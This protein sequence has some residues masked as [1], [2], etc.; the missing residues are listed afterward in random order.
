MQ[1]QAINWQSVRADYNKHKNQWRM[2]YEA[3]STP[4]GDG[5]YKRHRKVVSIRLPILDQWNKT[6]DPKAKMEINLTK[7]QE[8]KNKLIEKKYIRPLEFDY[9]RD[10]SNNI[11]HFEQNKSVMEKVSDWL[12]E[13]ATTKKSRNTRSTYTSLANRIRECGDPFFAEFNHLWINNFHKQQA[14]RVNAGQ[15]KQSTARNYWE[16]INFLLYEAERQ[17]KISNAAEIHKKISKVEQGE[18]RIGDY[19]T[20][21]ELQKLHETPFKRQVLKRAFLFCCWSG[22]RIREAMG[23]KWSDI[24]E[25]NSETFVKVTSRKNKTGEVIKLPS[26][27]LT[28]LEE[29]GEPNDDVF[30]GLTYNHSNEYLTIWANKAGINREVKTHDA[31]RT[32]AALIWSKTKNTEQVRV[33]MSH[34]DLKQTNTYLANFL[35]TTYALTDANDIFPAFD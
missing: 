29:R 28:Y 24:K 3:P 13:Y 23:L 33:Y 20:I 32:C 14:K 18:A 2:V 34:K 26:Q 35:G 1:S 11:L 7:E 22:L 10:L 31:R 30:L 25:A 27:A 8:R 4:L 12:D 19:F 16:D 6:Y 15:I 21:E 9:Q 17:D 5:K